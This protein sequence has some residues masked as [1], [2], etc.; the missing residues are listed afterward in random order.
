MPRV[1]RAIRALRKECLRSTR[2]KSGARGTPRALLANVDIMRALRTMEAPRFALR[3][4]SAK[5]YVGGS[6]A[7]SE[8]V[9]VAF[10]TMSP[11]RTRCCCHYPWRTGGTTAVIEHKI[12]YSKICA[13]AVKDSAARSAAVVRN[14]RAR[15]ACARRVLYAAAANERRAR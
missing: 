10:S 1:L 15:A 5:A 8:D 2:A 3:V 11:R 9:V 7:R 4:T 13:T 14:A 12:A 6:T